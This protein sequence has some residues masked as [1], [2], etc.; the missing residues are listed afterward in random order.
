MSTPCLFVDQPRPM[1]WRRVM[2]PMARLAGMLLASVPIQSHAGIAWDA[3]W[4]VTA[5]GQ[6][7]SIETFTSTLPPDVVVRRLIQGNARYDRYLVADG[8]VLL[9]GLGHDG[10]H[11]V[12]EVTGHPEGAQGYVSALYFD[13]SRLPST[14][15]L[16]GAN[17]IGKEGAVVSRRQAGTGLRSGRHFQF[18]GFRSGVTVLAGSDPAQPEALTA[19]AIDYS[20]D[21]VL[22]PSSTHP[23]MAV[24]VSMPGN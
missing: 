24:V 17:G 15:T 18:D 11:W 19:T 20:D 6:N 1:Q 13:P 3:P 7:L 23:S 22:I 16:A 12:A 8:R 10:A 4:N 21:T 5:N 9:S 2:G 14:P